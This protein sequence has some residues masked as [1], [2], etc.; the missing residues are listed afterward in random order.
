MKKSVFC[1]I[2][3][4]TITVL[5]LNPSKISVSYLEQLSMTGPKISDYIMSIASDKASMLFSLIP[6]RLISSAVWKG[7]GWGFYALKPQ[8]ETTQWAGEQVQKAGKFSLLTAGAAT[9]ASTAWL[10]TNLFMQIKKNQD[11]NQQIK[12][13]KQ[14]L[15]NLE[16]NAKKDSAEP[17]EENS[18]SLNAKIKEKQQELQHLIK[19]AS[20]LQKVIRITNAIKFPAILALIAA[21]Q[22]GQ[23]YGTGYAG[24]WLKFIGEKLSQWSV[25]IQ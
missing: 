25:K 8:L 14:Q 20:T 2:I 17:I 11:I 19:Q 12:Q 21:S 4:L 16:N 7:L 6:T 15:K 9:T 24:D 18:A 1:I 22:T 13:V 3:F 10:L 23:A 5:Y